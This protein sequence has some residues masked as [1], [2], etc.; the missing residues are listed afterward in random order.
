MGGIEGVLHIPQSFSI[1]GALPSDYLVSLQDTRWGGLPLYR[2]EVSLFFRPSQLG[3][4][5]SV[6]MCMIVSFIYNPLIKN[7]VCMF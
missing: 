6:Y 5:I 3:Y 2:D 1:T 4:F 7:K